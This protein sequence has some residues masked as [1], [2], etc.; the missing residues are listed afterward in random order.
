MAVWF[1]Q[2]DARF[3][4]FHESREQ[5][6]GRWHGAGEGPAQYLAD[7]PDGA[8]AEHIRHEDLVTRE[9]LGSSLRL[10]WAVEVDEAA[11]T[12]RRPRLHRLVL[13]GGEASSKIGRAH[14]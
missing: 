10:L 5:P 11:E 8:W 3:P 1:R 4:F 12:I 7:T 13:L 14:V 2:A 6:S 9:D